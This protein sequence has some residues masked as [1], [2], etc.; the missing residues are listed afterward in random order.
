M[1]FTPQFSGANRSFELVRRSLLGGDGLPFRD[2]LTVEQ[3]RQAF[4]AEGVSFGDASNGSASATDEGGIVYTMGVTL[5]AMLLQALFTDV[6]RSCRA[7]VQRVAIYCAL[8][9]RAVSST[10]TGAYCRAR[11]IDVLLGTV[12]VRCR[13]S[14]RRNAPRCGRQCRYERCRPKAAGI[15]CQSKN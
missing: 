5:W 15:L 7:A 2:A 10:N 1:S 11:A 3:M 9:G 6:H 14:S 12:L 8:L 4:E 13:R